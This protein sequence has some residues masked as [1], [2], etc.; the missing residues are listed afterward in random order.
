MGLAP[1]VNNGNV[2]L[3]TPAK[4]CKKEGVFKKLCQPD[5]CD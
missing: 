2:L 4:F 5:E 1:T 3:T